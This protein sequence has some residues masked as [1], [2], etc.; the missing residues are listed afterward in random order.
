MENTL[1]E[2]HDK[3]EK[4]IQHM[5]RQIAEKEL[6]KDNEIREQMDLREQET[7]AANAEIDAQG[8]RIWELEEELDAE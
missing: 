2:L 8:K 1:D 6:E 7:L 4:T 5:N 3:I